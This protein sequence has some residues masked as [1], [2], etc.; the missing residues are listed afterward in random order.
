MHSRVLCSANNKE[1]GLSE[2][3]E[4]VDNVI[5]VSASLQTQKE[6]AKI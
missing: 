5:K 1:I 6:L 4:P 3:T 2:L